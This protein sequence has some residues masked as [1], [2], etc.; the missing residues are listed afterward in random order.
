MIATTSRRWLLPIKPQPLDAIHDG[1][2]IF[3]VFFFWV[4]VIKAQV[5]TTRVV[6]RQT[7]VEADRLCMTDVQ[8]AIGL[9]REARNDAWHT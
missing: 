2:D 9:W 3:L 7:K 6:A 4:R 5:A 1:I 8:I